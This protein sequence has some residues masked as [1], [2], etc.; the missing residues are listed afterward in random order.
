MRSTIFILKIFL[1]CYCFL[2]SS[3]LLHHSN[4]VEQC[5]AIVDCCVCLSVCMSDTK[6]HREQMVGLRSPNFGTHVHVNK[7]S[8]P[9]NFQLIRQKTSLTIHKVIY[10]EIRCF[11]NFSITC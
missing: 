7:A 3:D 5:Y 10:S 9:T 11:Y 1:Y 4:E 6:C 8:W 2:Y